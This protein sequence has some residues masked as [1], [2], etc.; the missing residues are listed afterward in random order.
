MAFFAR[1]NPAVSWKHLILVIKQGLHAKMIDALK[2][3]LI[4]KILQTLAF[5]VHFWQYWGMA[6]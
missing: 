3:A 4:N 2:E 5:T 6:E 1:I